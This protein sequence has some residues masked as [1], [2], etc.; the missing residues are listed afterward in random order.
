MAVA[1]SSATSLKP[2]RCQVP[3]RRNRAPRQPCRTRASVA[4]PRSIGASEQTGQC[5]EAIATGD[6]NTRAFSQRHSRN[7]MVAFMS[8]GMSSCQQAHAPLRARQPERAAERNE[9]KASVTNCRPPSTLRRRARCGPPTPASGFRNARAIRLAT[10]TLAITNS[11]AAPPSSTSS[12][13]RM[14]PTITSVER[15]DAGAL[16]AVRVGILRLRVARRLPAARRA[17]PRSSRRPS[18][19]RCRSGCGS[20]AAGRIRR[21]M[22]RRPDLRAHH[23]A[24]T[25]TPAAIPRRSYRSWPLRTAAA[26]DVSASTEA[27]QPCGM[28]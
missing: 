7:G 20:F 22:Q 9:Q 1:S 5:D 27:L 23:A 12:T 17:R 24:R 21:R 11:S 8:A 6:A 2:S 26:N 4:R 19:G 28:S 10:L 16:I 13:G 14:S 25:G 15:Q 3:A 18:A